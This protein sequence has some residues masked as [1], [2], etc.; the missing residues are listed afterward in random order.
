VK[1]FAV[2]NVTT[3]E[4]YCPNGHEALPDLWRED[5]HS[6]KFCPI[7]GIPVEERIVPYDAPYCSDCNKPVNP[8][9]NYCPYCDS[10]AS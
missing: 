7:C 10:P 4:R 6:V 9:W 5:D 3:V 2:K 8:S 1:M